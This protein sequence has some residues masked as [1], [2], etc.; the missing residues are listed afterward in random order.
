MAKKK[1]QGINK[2]QA[3]RD[4]LKGNPNDG[5]KAISIALK[6][7]GISVEPNFVSNIKLK[8]KKA[9][10]EM[11]KKRGRPK[12]VSSAPVAS[13]GKHYADLVAAAEFIH[14]CGGI[15]PAKEALAVA[16]KVLEAVA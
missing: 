1:A 8:V 13:N 5:P 6:E 15:Q 9:N 7:R 14:A 2:S 11:P 3:V 12:A 16:A 10:G 4:Y